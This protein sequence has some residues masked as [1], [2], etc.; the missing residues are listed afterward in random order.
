MKRI[1]A[2]TFAEI[3]STASLINERSIL[4]TFGNLLTTSRCNLATSAAP[5]TVARKTHCFG[6]ACSDGG[7]NTA[8]KFG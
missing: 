7:E 2:V 6:A 4:D 1:A 5:F 3:L 8:K